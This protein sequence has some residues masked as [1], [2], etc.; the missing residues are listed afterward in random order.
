[1]IACPSCGGPT[2]VRET[3]SIGTARAR[4]R[5]QCASLDCGERV[6]TVEVPITDAAKGHHQLV[7]VPRRA[8]N[9]ALSA[10]THALGESTIVDDAVGETDETGIP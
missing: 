1:M 8:L 5:R 4:R 6:T 3:R 2:N 7:I 10:I 9:A